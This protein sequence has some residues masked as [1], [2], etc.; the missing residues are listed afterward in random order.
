MKRAYAI[1]GLLA[2]LSLALFLFSTHR[3]NPARSNLASASEISGASNQ[4]LATAPQKTTALAATQAPSFAGIASSTTNA[5]T[6]F[7]AFATWTKQFFSG[8][9][10]ANLVQGQAL[11]WKRHEAMRELIQTDPERAL[12]LA[13]PYSW[14]RDLPAQITKYF[15]QQVDGRGALNVAIATDFN[16]SKVATYRFAKLDGKTY[17]AF[18]Y[19]RRTAQRSQSNIPLHGI[20]IDGEMAVSV[21]VLRKLD[22]DEAA[23]VDAATSAAE[24]ICGVSGKPSDWRGQEVV[25]ESGGGILHF[26][27]VDHYKLANQRLVLAESGGTG[28]VGGSGIVGSASAVNDAWT[29]GNKS[30]LYIRVNFPDDLTEPISEAGA[31]SVMDSVNAFYTESSYDLTSLTTTVTPLV[32]VPQMKAWYA[33]ADAGPTALQD[34]AREAAREAGYD[35]SN[36]DLDIIAFTSVPGFDFGGLAYVGGKG[37]WLQSYGAGVTAHELGHNYGLFH[38]N[39][40]N[41]VTNTSSFGPGTN[42]E[43]GNIFDTMGL[44]LAGNNQFNAAFKSILDWLKADA[45]QTVTSNGVY[46]IYPFDDS[47]RIDGNM[48]AAVVKKDALRDYWLEF[49]RKFTGNPWMQNGLMLNWSPWQGSSGGTQLIDTTPGSADPGDDKSRDD[50]AVVIGRTFNDQQAG[51]HITPLAR[52]ATGTNAWIDVQVNTGA[53]PGNQAP[54]LQLEVDQTNVAPGDLVHFH[55]TATDEDGDTLA[56]AWSCDDLT[57]S[58]NNLPWYSK[59]WTDAGEHV[60]RCVVSDMK[61][62]VASA[63]TVVTVGGATG[64]RITGQ[65]TDTNGVPLEGVLVSNGDPQNFVGGYTDTEGN[66]V[67]VGVTNQNL[68]LGAALF[69]YTFAMIGNWYNPL[70]LSSNVTGVNFAGTSLPT[71]N[72]LADTNSILE[73]DAGMH[74]ITITR[75]GDT[76][77]DLTVQVYLSG[78][79]TLGSDYVLSGI[80]NGLN[81]L[82]IPA[83]TNSLTL[84]F[85]VINDS[86]VEGPEKVVLTIIDDN[87]NNTQ[88]TYALAPLAE[89][90]ITIIDDDAAAKPTVSVSTTTP[91]I[92]ENGTDSGQFVFT[93]N[94]NPTGDLLVYYSVAGTAVAGTDYTPL[95]GVVLIPDGQSSTTIPFLPIDDK[96]VESNETV[97]ATITTDAA[98]TVGSPSSATVTILDDGFM[99]VTISPTGNA[100]KPSTPG[101]FTVQRNGDLSDNLVVFYNVGGSAVPDTDYAALPNSV[102]I[103][104]GVASA[105]INVT[106]VHNSLVEGDVTVTVSLTNDFNYDIGTPGTASIVIHDDHLPT[107]SISTTNLTGIPEQGNQAGYFT[108]SRSGSTS[109]SLTVNLAISG[110]ATPG[111]DY[112]PIDNTVVIPDGS[113]SADVELIPFDDLILEPTETVYVTV[114]TNASYNVGTPATAHINILDNGLSQQPGIGFCFS[115]SA[116]VES[117]SPGIAVGLSMTSAVPVSVN[118]QVIGGTAPSNRYSLP[119]GTLTINPNN[120]VGFIPL[121]VQNDN[122]VEP[123]QTVKV[124]LFSPTNAT[125]DA[126]KTHTYTILDDDTNS[127][128]V[129]ATTPAAS[130]SGT[131]GNFRITRAGSTASNLLVNFQITGSASAPTDYQPLGTSVTIPAGASFVDLPVTP[132]ADNTYEFPQTVVMTLISAPGGQ[133]V[134]PNNATVTIADNST[135]PLPL[136]SITS[137]NAPVAVEGGGNG[138]FL[139]TRDGD[140]NA[141]LTISYAISGS[142]VNGVRYTTLPTSVTIPAGQYSVALPVVAIDDSVVEGE[143]TV[144]LSLIDNETYRAVYPSSATVTIQDNDQRVW[145]D[146]SDF[147]ASKYGPDPGEFTFSRFGTTNSAVEIFYTISGTASNGLDY[148]TITNS[149]IIPA[150]DLTTTLPIEPLHNGIVKGPVTVTLTLDTNIAYILGAPT[151]ATVT[152]GDDMPEVTI[153]AVIDTVQEGSQ[154]NGVFRVTRTGDPQFDFTAHLQVDGTATYGVDYPP[155][156]TNVYFSC[157][158]MAVDLAVMPTNDVVVEGDETVVASLIP[159]PTY[160]ILAPSNAVITILDVG[161]NQNPVVTITLPTNNIVFT[162]ATNA[163]F[164]LQGTVTDDGDTNLLVTWWSQV[165]GPNALSFG[166]TNQINTTVTFTNTG[167]Y[168]LRLTASDGQLQSY[169]EVTFVVGSSDSLSTNLLHWRLD[170]AS[171]TNAAD[172]SGNGRDGVFVGE[173]LWTNGII[174]G[175]LEFA[176]TNDYVL[177]TGGTNVVNTDILDGLSAFTISLWIKPALTNA[178]VGFVAADPAPGTNTT[179]SFATHSFASCGNYTNVLEVV[180]P[181]TKGVAHRTSANN[182]VIP[183]QWQHVAITWSNGLAP[184]LYI[185]GQLDQPSVEMAVLKGVLTNCPQFLIGKGAGD[186][187]NSWTGTI[188]DVRVFDRALTAAEILAL[189]GENT[190]TNHAPIVDAGTNQLVTLGMPVTIGGTVSD[191]GLPNPP[192]LVTNEWTLVSGPVTNVVIPDPLSLTNTMTFLTAGDYVFRLTAS[193]GELVSYADVTITV[194]E[195]PHVSVYASPS[196]AYE[197]GP[198]SGAFT[199]TRNN[200]TNELTVYFTI[201]GT[202]SNGTDYV[203]ITN[204]SVTFAPDTNSITLDVTPFLDYLIEGDETVTLTIVSNLSYAIDS[205]SATVT[206]H[207]S[208]YGVWSIQ[209]F[210]LEQLTHPELTG[211]GADFDSDGYVNFVEYALNLDP[212]SPETNSPLVMS[213]EVNTNDNLPHFTLTYHRRVQPTDVAYAVYFGNDLFNLNT[214]TN[215][216]EEFSAV[217]DNNNLTE[218]VKVRAVQPFSTST[219]QFMTLRVWLQQPPAP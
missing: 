64:Y 146:A 111:A 103:P 164:I 212:K 187:T 46:R 119:P 168:V 1:C 52:G 215:Y 69:P 51:V 11:A 60:V 122:V 80:N 219:N 158:V 106:P 28:A 126:I 133:I 182:A 89:A 121:Q 198:Q 3:R 113:S 186:T 108:I 180:I 53:F 205:G 124:V 196:D 197:L 191:D 93:R 162:A 96:A 70:S 31:Y 174:G 217:S 88:P 135:N 36:Y 87:G 176:G 18:V 170:D 56:Y 105:E 115:N 12:S 63:N 110:T 85:S 83:G 200:V 156:E 44:A 68:T 32:T 58:T 43:Y 139:F 76:N 159:D 79:A 169:Q 73:S 100:T 107:V 91:D 22:A 42:L 145:I 75:T 155:F 216:V 90:T 203:E 207:D 41:A 208:P 181:T 92:S 112:L 116:V 86:L 39:L 138:E 95:A 6:E 194:I 209:Q 175:A 132:V 77:N 192:A 127:V 211:P 9:S 117:Q 94:G 101:S 149:V 27:G 167:V 165:S 102:T 61:G 19:G 188:D 17:Q 179:L 118:Y 72:I 218:T 82:V 98:Y 154:S 204:T 160:S 123:P 137:S 199:I 104:A 166:D 47:T 157:G 171:G 147:S 35:T 84:P 128:S 25:A 152:I 26:C 57:F 131:V 206:L 55:A 16:S 183:G 190:L 129:T 151:N 141:S 65:V 213:F 153:S 148:A 34:D 144:T 13:V 38:A 33:S 23:A 99:T 48:Y 20:A 210:T 5:P 120:W 214:G 173:P 4:T 130:E 97:V 49:R 150:G 62:G 202:A 15:E 21:D 161:T 78:T 50:A 134:S 201:G 195:P 172:A 14:R 114:V 142:A 29:H 185:N 10:S 7:D 24:K 59:T 140:T 66:Y 54:E 81:T 143:E 125:L 177:E 8:T 37:L 184:A 67:I 189:D 136:V 30:V 163:G 193:D 40:W 2:C 109:G 45:V 74:S 71:V 178:D